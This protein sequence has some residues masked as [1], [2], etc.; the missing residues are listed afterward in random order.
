MQLTLLGEVLE[1]GE[2]FGGRRPLLVVLCPAL[3]ELTERHDSYAKSLAEVRDFH[4]FH[5]LRIGW[6][7]LWRGRRPQ[8]CGNDRPRYPVRILSCEGL[9]PSQEFP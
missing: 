8:A 3:R 6:R 4:L 5:K 2:D 1:H 7:E 9:L